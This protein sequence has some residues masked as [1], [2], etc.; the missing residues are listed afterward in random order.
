MNDLI[1]KFIEQIQLADIMVVT[2]HAPYMDFAPVV[3]FDIIYIMPTDG[4]Q[5]SDNY[6]RDCFMEFDIDLLE[7]HLEYGGLGHWYG[8]IFDC[9]S[10]S[11]AEGFK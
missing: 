3:D 6:S 4:I 2:N 1:S 11:K 9:I 5:T 7:Q 8:T 10:F